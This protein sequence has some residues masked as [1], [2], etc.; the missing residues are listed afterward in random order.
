MA[1]LFT[2]EVSVLCSCLEVPIVA[3]LVWLASVTGSV[4][5]VDGVFNCAVAEA[6]DFTVAEE[7]TAEGADIAEVSV[8][9]VPVAVEAVPVSVLVSV[10]AVDVVPSDVVGVVSVGV[11]RLS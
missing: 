11:L 9:P 2:V 4:D 1:F 5:I 10:V 6:L 3:G 8:V 7:G